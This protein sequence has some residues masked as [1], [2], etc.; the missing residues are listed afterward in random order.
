[1]HDKLITLVGG[2]GFLGRYIVK[3][4]AQEDWVVRVISR[5]PDKSLA[6]K[7]AGTVG[8]IVL[9]P[10][11]LAR[12]ET[13][14][15]K[16]DGSYAVVNLVGTLFESGRQNF[17]ALHAQGP[18][19]L[20]KL[21]KAAGVKKFVHISSLGVDRA[22][23]SKYARTKMLGEQA[24]MAA[25]P[26]ATILRPGV[27]FGAEDQFFNKFARMAL[28]SPALPLI[29]G[30]N[31]K[32]QPVYVDDVAQAVVRVATTSGYEGKIYELAGPKIYSFRQLLEYI[33]QQTGRPRMLAKIPYGLASL[34]SLFTEL[35]PSPPLTRDQ[36]RLLQYDNV[37]SPNAKT[38]ADLGIAATPVELVVPHYLRAYR[39]P[40]SSE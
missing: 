31:T 40:G 21:A 20:A 22:V 39:K 6:L 24:V 7:T 37:V 36:I 32:F 23:S 29:G 19:K 4:L 17:A 38:L 2:T 26:E 25:F 9:V 1:M 33:G 12:P 14:E 8:Q 11:D 16:L 13:L 30:G 10:G 35:L 5:H 28:I 34:M 3:R 18:E 15:N 27:I